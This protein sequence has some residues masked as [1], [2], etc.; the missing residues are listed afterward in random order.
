MQSCLY[1]ADRNDVWQHKNTDL[2]SVILPQ[3]IPSDAENQKTIHVTHGYLSV[4]RTPCKTA[5][6]FIVPHDSKSA[7]QHNDVPNSLAS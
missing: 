7:D 6:R 3:D 5:T 2:Y 4:G 1:Q